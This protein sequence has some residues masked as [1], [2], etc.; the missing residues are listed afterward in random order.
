[1]SKRHILFVDDDPNLLAGIRRLLHSLRNDFEL[2]FANN[3]R[4]ALEMMEGTA[5]DVV[6]SDM[7][8]PGM[9]GAELL[10]KIQ[11]LYPCTIR[12]ML[13][14]QADGDAILRTVGV[15]HQFLE[16]PSDP[17]MLKSVLIR[18][19]ALYNLLADDNIKEIVSRIES[20]PSLPDIYVRLQQA[21][22]SPNVSVAEVAAIIE[23]DMAMSTKVLQLV[24]S[25]FFGMFQTVE[26]PARAVA[27]LGLD[28]IKGLALG[29]HIFS[30]MKNVSKLFSLNKLMQHSI[31]VATCAK[32]IAAAE[33]NDKTIIDHSFIAGILHDV[34]KLILASRLQDQY[35]E[36]IMLA[37]EQ[38]ISQCEAE[39][40][41]FHSGH[42]II[43]AYLIGIWGM[44][45]AVVEAIAFH[46]CLEDYPEHAFSPA[47]AVHVANALY[48]ENKTDE[49]GKQGLNLAYLEELGLSDRIEV[50]REIC[51]ELL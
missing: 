40:Q 6:V 18:S 5:F 10:K 33:T 38:N 14:G 4:E 24:N 9:D 45:G 17:E 39:L 51:A 21:M 1:M 30:E 15:V 20:L 49:G 31:A 37:R 16:K 23:K 35:D 22:I 28:T 32:K 13:S 41:I 50:W 26:S 7:R 47:L 36:A 27:L 48:H 46:H 44:P 11:E 42:G 19:S 2:A 12:I 8:M 25:A 43:G 34:G 29:V 3:G